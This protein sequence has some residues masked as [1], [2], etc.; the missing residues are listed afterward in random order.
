MT[1]VRDRSFDARVRSTAFYHLRAL[2]EQ[3][4]KDKKTWSDKLR[5]GTTGPKGEMYI[6]I[7]DE[8]LQLFKVQIV[9]GINAG[10]EIVPNCSN[11]NRYLIAKQEANHMVEE[12]SREAQKRM[13]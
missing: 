5:L 3:T 4:M 2:T 11:L 13:N 10:I 1:S 6:S 7:D 12:A 8:V 9:P